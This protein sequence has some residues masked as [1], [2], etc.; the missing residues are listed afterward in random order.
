MP[1]SRRCIDSRRRS[2][3]RKRP[4]DRPYP[5]SVGAAGFLPGCAVGFIT[6]ESTLSSACSSCRCRR[7]G[8][9]IE[10]TGRAPRSD[11]RESGGA[12]RATCG[13]LWASRGPSRSPI[14]RPCRQIAPTRVLHLVPAHTVHSGSVASPDHCA[15]SLRGK[16]PS[17]PRPGSASCAHD[18]FRRTS[19]NFRIEPSATLALSTERAQPQHVDCT[20]EQGA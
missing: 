7:S 1:P 20:C 3:L 12:A 5:A 14:T 8:S 10:S 11:R 4:L 13:P 16:D 2:G 17:P 18:D 9:S 19:G 15:A 6:R